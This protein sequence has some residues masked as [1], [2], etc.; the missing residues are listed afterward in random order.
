MRKSKKNLGNGPLTAVA[1]SL[2]IFGGE[3][4]ERPLT[5]SLSLRASEAGSLGK[6]LSDRTFSL[7]G[8]DEDASVV[9]ITTGRVDK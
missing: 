7:I 6:V 9:L 5:D 8:P 1:G 4:L 3:V 2:A